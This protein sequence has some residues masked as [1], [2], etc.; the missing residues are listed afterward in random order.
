MHASLA[1]LVTALEPALKTNDSGQPRAYCENIFDVPRAEL[2]TMLATLRNVFW[3][4]SITPDNREEPVNRAIPTKTISSPA[5]IPD[6]AIELP[7]TT[8]PDKETSLAIAAQPSTTKGPRRKTTGLWPFKLSMMRQMKMDSA[9]YNEQEILA[10]LAKA[11]WSPA[12]KRHLARYLLPVALAM[13][14]Q[15]VAHALQR[16]LS[17]KG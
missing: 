15:A 14:R 16:W 2:C 1:E 17:K 9:R 4:H 7:Q 3:S 5:A 13:R 8:E 11:N 12:E 10:S 6:R